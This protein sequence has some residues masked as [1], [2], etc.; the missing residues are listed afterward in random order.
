MESRALGLVHPTEWKTC[1]NFLNVLQSLEGINYAKENGIIILTLVPH[2]SNRVQPLNR[3][4]G[5]GA[6][7]W[8]ISHPEKTLTIFDITV[9]CVNAWENG[10]NPVNVKSE[11][12][13][14]EMYPFNRGA[15]NESIYCPVTSSIDVWYRRDYRRSHHWGSRQNRCHYRKKWW[16]VKL[17]TNKRQAQAMFLLHSFHY[18]MRLFPKVSLSKMLRQRPVK[19]RSVIATDSPEMQKLHKRKMQKRKEW[20]RNSWNSGRRGSYRDLWSSGDGD[21]KGNTLAQIQNNDYVV[22]TVHGKTVKLTRHFVARQF[23][24][25]TK[26]SFWSGL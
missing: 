25:D 23:F 22:S 9:I 21:Q 24:R 12:R 3:D 17:L 16:N 13:C 7:K 4:S 19:N 2:T 10:A 8:M 6:D 26:F 11:L 14:T 5:R 20:R 1:E 15:F 18:Q